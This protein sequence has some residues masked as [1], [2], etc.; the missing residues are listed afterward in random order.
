MLS[1]GLVRR[2]ASWA[3]PGGGPSSRS[4]ILVAGHSSREHHSSSLW[5]SATSSPTTSTWI[6]WVSAQAP[7]PQQ[8]TPPP[9]VRHALR[10]FQY[11][12]GPRVASPPTMARH[13]SEPRVCRRVSSWNCV[14]CSISNT[15]H[16]RSASHQT[17][18]RNFPRPTFR[19]GAPPQAHPHG[20]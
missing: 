20:G 2:L 7:T 1:S 13:S 4:Q 8:K 10:P 6:S 14:W 3:R 18:C 9:K 16:R 19:P 12:G 17:S 11:G 5:N 15:S